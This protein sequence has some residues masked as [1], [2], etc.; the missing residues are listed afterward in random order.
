MDA[1][2]KEILEY[3]DRFMKMVLKSIFIFLLTMFGISSILDLMFQS[4]ISIIVS[5]SVSIICTIFYCTL[6]IIEK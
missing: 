6:I 4:D 1:K 3:N 5:F 2:D